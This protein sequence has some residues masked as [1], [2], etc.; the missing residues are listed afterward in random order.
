MKRRLT[1]LL[2]VLIL[3]VS[4]SCAACRAKTNNQPGE[5]VST[6]EPAVVPTQGL[7]EAPETT[8]NELEW[9]MGEEDFDDDAQETEPTKSSEAGR[10]D[11]DSAETKPSDKEP[12]DTKPAETEPSDKEPADTEPSDT[13]PADTEPAE[14]EPADTKPVDT[15]PAE[16]EPADTEPVDK[17]PTE[18]EP[19]EPDW[20]MGGE[21]F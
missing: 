2:L 10:T 11:T 3:L 13:E 16:T 21:D 4:M 19:S 5:D 1:P 6:T 8:P 18:T 20:G 15:K 9:G 17:E 12:A 7:T 14:T